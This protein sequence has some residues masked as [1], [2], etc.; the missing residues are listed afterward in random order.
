L[1]QHLLK[2]RVYKLYR[3]RWNDGDKSQLRTFGHASQS[4]RDGGNEHNLYS[5]GNAFRRLHWQCGFECGRVADGLD[6]QF[7]SEFHHDVGN[8][9]FD[10]HYREFNTGGQLPPIDHWE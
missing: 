5:V 1:R 6:G 3:D 9:D 2:F 7:Q 10:S 8:L 4:N